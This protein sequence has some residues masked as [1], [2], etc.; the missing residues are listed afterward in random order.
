MSMLDLVAAL[1]KPFLKSCPVVSKPRAIRRIVEVYIDKPVAL[2][3][4]E[5]PVPFVDRRMRGFL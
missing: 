3:R 1:T 4:L 5:Q 2:D